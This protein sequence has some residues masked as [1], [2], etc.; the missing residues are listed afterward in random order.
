M[1]RRFW[2]D[3]LGRDLR[4]AARSLARN[5]AF[6]IVAVVT[7]ALGIGANTAIFSIVHAVILSPLPFKNADQL[8][9]LYENVPAAESPNGKAM[10]TGVFARDLIDLSTHAR[11]VSHV[12]TT[13]TAVVAVQGGADMQRQKL[14][15]VTVSTFPMLGVQPKIG[16][17]FAA[18]D[19]AP[20]RDRIIVLSYGAWQR[21]FGGDPQAL[22]KPLTFNGDNF[23]ARVAFGESYT[24]VGVMPAGF[25]F[26]DDDTEF[27]IPL[28][29]STAA[30]GPRPPRTSLL[31]RLAPGTSPQTAAAEATAILE[32]TRGAPRGSYVNAAGPPRFEFER[33]QDIANRSVRPAVIVL[34]AA[35]GCVL[36]IAY[37]N[38]A[39]L[40]LARTAARQREIAVRVA[41]GA[42]RSRLI[43]QVLTES[44][45]L[46]TIGG[47]L[48]VALAAAGIRLFRMLATSLARVDLGSTGTTFPRLDAIGIDQPVLAFAAAVSIGAGLLF[49][50]VPAL[51]SSRANQMDVLR[52]ATGTTAGG[53]SGKRDTARRTLVVAEIALATV[54]MIA[55]ALLIR[56]FVG[57]A[58]VHLGYDPSNVLTF[59]ITLPGG[60]RPSS[61]LKIF[62][63]DLAARI[64]TVP[65][66]KAA[67]YANQLPLVGL[68]NKISFRTTPA[69]PDPYMPPPQDS[70]DVRL[71][72]R[73]Y[74]E[75]MGIRIVTGR[76]FAAA[77]DAGA[78]HVVV[79]NEK[80]A[81]REFA[82]RNPVGTTV[83]LSLSTVP[84]EVVGVVQDVRQVG[85]DREPQPQVFI[86]MR[87][88]SGQSVPV[89][90]IGP[91]FGVRTTQV[92]ST[93]AAIRQ[94]VQQEKPGAALDNVATMDQIVSNA[95]TVPRMYAVLIGIFAG[96]AMTLAAA[97]IY[98][99][100]AYSVTQR[101]REIGIRMALGARRGQVVTLVLSQ[102][103]TLIAIGLIAG[104]G[105]AAAGTRYLE[106][107]LFGLTP[108]DP[109]TFA[110]VAA[111]FGVVALLA[112]YVPARRATRVD[113]LV[114]L[115]CE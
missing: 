101:T 84:W 64:R 4:Y 100:V 74:V 9:Q 111:V 44:V 21:Y 20:G 49:G 104:L 35:V 1:M 73:D 19:D 68:M 10:R 26:P 5:P 79:I 89:F 50:L 42:G 61:E 23:G 55:G 48:G 13:G 75:T 15:S 27:W 58:R 33:L 36:L 90:P 34:A 96:V 8:V 43:R 71:V 67:S 53:D 114:A 69:P 2:I 22:G 85:L 80:L 57:L 102:S 78:R 82:G 109:S 18:G 7:L 72:S 39:N 41:I 59:Q 56:S 95:M 77:D 40:L 103:L 17:W 112:S 87:Q 38:V 70:P 12:A 3:D 28:A 94:I 88:W 91:Y 110:Y 107:L 29:V 92:A 86:D 51:R 54:L 76:A 25:H 99:V 108:L 14:T 31:A 52:G 83:Y 93:I 24:V 65:G 113:P 6:S 30:P 105:G 16:R 47:V 81:R 66:V 98:G 63:E 106:G 60:R 46:S 32:S 45:L 115:R 97:G 37:A 62:A 11:T